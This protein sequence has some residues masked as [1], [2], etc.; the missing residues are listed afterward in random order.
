MKILSLYFGQHFLLGMNFPL[1]ELVSSLI[2]RE[3][4]AKHLGE[5]N[6]EHGHGPIHGLGYSVLIAMERFIPFSVV[7]TVG[8]LGPK[9]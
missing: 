6:S 5:F 1:V 4:Q 8:C 7:F 2:C 9:R 3:L